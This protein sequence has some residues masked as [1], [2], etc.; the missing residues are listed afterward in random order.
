MKKLM[1]LYLLRIV[2]QGRLMKKEKEN[3]RRKTR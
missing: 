1:R 2:L 3:G